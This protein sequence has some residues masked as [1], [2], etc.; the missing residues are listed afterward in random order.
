M[1]LC[2]LLLLT[3]FCLFCCVFGHFS[4]WLH[5]NGLY[6]LLSVRNCLSMRITWPVLLLNESGENNVSEKDLAVKSKKLSVQPC[7][8][9]WVT[10]SYV[11][12]QTPEEEEVL[13]KKRSKRTQK[14]YDERK[15]TAKISTLLE[16]QFQQGKLL[17]ESLLLHNFKLWFAIVVQ[18]YIFCMCIRT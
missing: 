8:L 13:N 3:C 12:L 1:G 16:E 11:S 4:L 9:V 17:G 14:K 15:K 10:A 6:K 5:S 7:G 18:T 2:S